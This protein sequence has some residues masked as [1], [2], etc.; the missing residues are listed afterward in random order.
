M[1]TVWVIT[2]AVVTVVVEVMG[3][4]VIFAVMVK[5]ETEVEGTQPEVEL[6]KP[7]VEELDSGPVTVTVTG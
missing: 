6:E 3:G 7:V 1:V 4:C 2:V 5:V